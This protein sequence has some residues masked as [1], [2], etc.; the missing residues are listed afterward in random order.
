MMWYE[1]WYILLDQ[2]FEY[3]MLSHYSYFM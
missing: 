3:F 2:V 1:G